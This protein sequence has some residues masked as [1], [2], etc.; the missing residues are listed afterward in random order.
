MALSTRDSFDRSRIA[1]FPSQII[2]Y[3]SVLLQ[4]R[5]EI[6]SFVV[7]V[8][9]VVRMTFVRDTKCGI[10]HGLLARFLYHYLVR[11]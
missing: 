11:P 6:M 7:S 10:T 3:Q 5:D 1:I 4:L 2:V 8:E 9:Q